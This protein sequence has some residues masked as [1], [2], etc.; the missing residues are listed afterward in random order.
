M[1]QIISLPVQGFC[2]S[3]EGSSVHLKSATI[4][5]LTFVNLKL[6][7]AIRVISLFFKIGTAEGPEKSS[8]PSTK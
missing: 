1:E 2:L 7:H 6:I 4:Y 8:A 3:N 5:P